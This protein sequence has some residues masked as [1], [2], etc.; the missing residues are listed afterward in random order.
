MRAAAG[1]L[2]TAGSGSIVC[3]ASELSLVGQAD[4][5]AYTASKGGVLAMARSLAA[6]LA[7]IGIR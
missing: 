2:S 5:V 6:E 7:P 3:I 4:Y 1:A